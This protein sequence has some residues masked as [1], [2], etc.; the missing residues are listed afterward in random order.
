MRTSIHD[1][2]KFSVTQKF[3]GGQIVLFPPVRAVSE[4]EG[5]SLVGPSIPRDGVGRSRRRRRAARYR[6]LCPTG[7]TLHPL[8]P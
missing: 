5:T 2:N 6:D 7:R 3:T 4:S 1:S 8:W